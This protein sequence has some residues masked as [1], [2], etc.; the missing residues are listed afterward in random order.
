MQGPYQNP[1]YCLIFRSLFYLLL[2]SYCRSEAQYQCITNI[3]RSTP[4]LYHIGITKT[5]LVLTSALSY[6]S[7]FIYAPRWFTTIK[8]T[9]QEINPK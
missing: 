2:F 6:F 4:E 8:L 3:R 5:F 1:L 9:P 7:I